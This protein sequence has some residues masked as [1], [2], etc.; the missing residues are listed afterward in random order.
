MLKTQTP[1][2]SAI[3][4]PK[5]I[6]NELKILTE[7]PDRAITILQKTIRAEI[8]RMEQGKAQIEQKLRK[9]EQKYQT[10]SSEFIISW[11]AENLEGKDL[12][13]IEW[14]GEYQCLENIKQD[15][16]ILLSLQNISQNVSI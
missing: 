13:Y 7:Y 8:L 2:L 5:L 1:Y 10:S 14:S 3:I 6:M 9:F 11:T 12:E 16:Q 15:L 4:I